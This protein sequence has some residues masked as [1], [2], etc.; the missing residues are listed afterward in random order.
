MTPQASHTNLR[1]ELELDISQIR[2]NLFLIKI[3]YYE[4][5][6]LEAAKHLF[7]APSICPMDEQQCG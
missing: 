5:K 3:F 7:T 6:L 1:G 4:L 2:S